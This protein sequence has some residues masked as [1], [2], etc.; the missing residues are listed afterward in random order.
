MQV[1]KKMPIYSGAA[2]LRSMADMQMYGVQSG[3]H[4]LAREGCFSSE[5]TSPFGGIG[6][7]VGDCRHLALEVDA[8]P[9]RGVGDLGHGPQDRCCPQEASQ[10]SRGNAGR[11]NR[12]R[13]VHIMIFH[14]IQHLKFHSSVVAQAGP[15][16]KTAPL[17]QQCS[18]ELG[19]I[20]TQ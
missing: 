4:R 17:N 8:D 2:R 9:G 5:I 15:H 18:R 19:T 16:A 1:L 13:L 20:G 3:V 7:Q 14:C 11:L 6:R 10:P 12:H